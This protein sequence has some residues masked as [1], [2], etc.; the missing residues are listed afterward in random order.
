M[1]WA[2]LIAAGLNLAVGNYALAVALYGAYWCCLLLADDD[3]GDG[4]E[5]E[6]LDELEDAGV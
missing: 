6:E 5:I 3:D 4:G 1:R 2:W